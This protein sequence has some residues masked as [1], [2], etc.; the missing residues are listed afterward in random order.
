ML[1]RLSLGLL[2]SA[3]SVA[4]L[5]AI[6]QEDGSADDLGVMSISLK[7]VVKPTFG[8][9]GALQ[10]A[11]TPN[12]AGIGGFLP[13]SVGENSVWFL[14]VLANANFADYENNSSIMNT[15][16]AGTTISTSSRLG[17]RWLNSDRN[18]MYGLNAGYD[19]R[20]MNT[21]ATDYGIPLFGTERNVFFQQVAVN[22]EAVSNDWNFNAYALIP[23][24]DTEQILNWAF[25]GGALDTYGIDVG[26]FITP[27]LNA[28]VGY[29]YQQGDLG[30][31]DGSGVLGR[32]AYEVSSGLIAGVNFSYDEA[33][34]TRVSADLKVRFGGASTTAH[35]KVVQQQPVISAL[36]M[37]PENRDVR[38]HDSLWGDIKGGFDDVADVADD[39]ASGVED[40]ADYTAS[41]LRAIARA[42]IKE[43]RIAAKNRELLE[44]L[45]G[46][47]TEF[48]EAAGEACVE[49]LCEAAAI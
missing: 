39:V 36:T 30:S 26:Y 23:V 22:A 41:E 33:F 47:A 21:G 48:A 16:V 17:Y 29:Y 12:Q 7:D 24:G 49:G 37:S 10:G 31:A 6:A 2:A 8:F 46:D 14:D 34:E 44:D 5:P 19:S 42:A 18:W 13:L 35:R 4:A 43:A 32:V 1:R 27:A 45:E 20:P 25:D 15:Q 9:Q 11:G 28:S 3:I 40:A 38:V